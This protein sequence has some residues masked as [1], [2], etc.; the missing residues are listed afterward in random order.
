MSVANR[1]RSR[2][3]KRKY[4]RR[5]LRQRGGSI[6]RIIY[7]FWTGRNEIPPSRKKCLEELTAKSGCKVQVVNPD[8]LDS[9]ILPDAPL[10]PGYEFLS[11]VHKSDY[12][13]TYFM[14]FHGGGYSDMKATT[15]DWNKAFDDIIHKRD[16][17][18]NS[19]HE[20]DPNG[21]HGTHY[22][23]SLWK[24][25]PGTCAFIMRPKSEFTT[26]WYTQMIQKMDDKLEALKKHPAKD[27]RATP[28]SQ[29]GYPLQWTE[30]LADIF[31]PLACDYRG[32][33]LF[34]VPPPDFNKKWKNA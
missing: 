24:E 27:P 21:V 3:S 4:R 26:A 18:I 30:L 19:Y 10:H 20:P 7:T 11:Q 12:L 32:K 17:L 13:R 9:Y 25:L 23:R 8:N 14:H 29:P 6:Q 28:K 34:T 1:G 2:K 5:T 33:Y 16:I 22:A 15:G 31:H